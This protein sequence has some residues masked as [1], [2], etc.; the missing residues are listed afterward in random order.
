MPISEQDDVLHYGA[1][2]DIVPECNPIA[3]MRVVHGPDPERSAVLGG[4]M[5]FDWDAVTC[6]ACL[7]K[8]NTRPQ[9]ETPGGEVR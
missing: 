2:D 6:P 1:N 3:D 7:A 5:V 9:G 4:S 8:R